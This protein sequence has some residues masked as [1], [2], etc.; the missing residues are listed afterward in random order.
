VNHYDQPRPRPFHGVIINGP[1]P[2]DWIA[3]YELVVLVTLA[4]FPLALVAGYALARWRQRSGMSRAVASRRAFAEVGLVY[5]TAPWIWL[6]MLPAN[7]GAAHRVVSLVPLRDLATMPPYQVLGNLLV[8]AALGLFGPI[9]YPALRSVP[10]VGLV[11]A[12]VSTLIELSQYALDLGRVAS[13]DDVLLN[14]TGATVAALLSWPA[15]HR[16]AELR[17]A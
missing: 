7:S 3:R 17:A 11:A 5:G 13:I 10:A 4:A 1:A 12:G 9:R 14:T 15:W 2:H 6:T 8:L 16:R